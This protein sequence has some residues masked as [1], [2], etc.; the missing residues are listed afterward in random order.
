[1]LDGAAS[2]N[3]KNCTLSSGKHP[4]R[5]ELARYA[6]TIL[7]PDV[8]AREVDVFPAERRQVPK[9]TFVPGWI[10]SPYGMSRPFQVHGVPEH[11]GRRDQVQ[12]AGT[13][14]L[15]LKAAVTQFAQS[16]EEHGSP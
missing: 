10:A 2:E 15:L 8:V 5:P 11:N 7:P 16:G 14:A 4:E 12:A 1:M 6:C 3:G 13:M 9:Q